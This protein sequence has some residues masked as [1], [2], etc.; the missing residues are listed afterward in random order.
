M[1]AVISNCGMYRYRL[2]RTVSDSGPVFAFFGVNP[3]TADASS[4]DSTV[5]KWLGFTR[6]WGGSRFIVGNVFAYRSTDVRQLATVEDAFGDLIGDHTTDIINEADILV[7]CWGKTAKVPPSLQFAFDVLMDALLSS[8]KPVKCFGL[9]ASGDPRHPLMLGYSTP[10]VDY[11]NES[12][13]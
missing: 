5:R 1:N 6:R 12:K 4:D 11:K 7:P 10:L 3:S 2:D 13:P 9:T 8:G